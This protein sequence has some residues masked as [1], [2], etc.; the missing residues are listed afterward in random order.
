MSGYWQVE[1]H[2]ADRP[3]TAFGT[4]EGLFQ[5]CVIPFGLSNA[6]ATFQ[7][8][9]DLVLAGLQWSECLVYLDDVIVLGRSFEEHLKNLQSVLQRL[10]QAGLRLKLSKCS[11]FQHQ[12]KYLG[13]IISR[14]GVATDPAKTQKVAH[15]P[16]P[17]SKREVHVQQFLGFAGYYR[18]FIREF[19][20]T[21]RPLH[22]LTERTATFKWT[23]ECAAAFQALHQ[24]LYST[25][26]LAYPDFTRL[27]ILDTDASD[28]GIGAVLS[29]TSSDGNERVIAYGSRL[30]TKPERQYCVTRHELLAVVYFTN[31]Y[32]SYLTGR[33]FVLRTD[34]GSL[35]WL[36]NFEDPEG[37]LAHWLEC[38][39]DLEFE[40]VH[41]R[42]RSHTN[43]DALSRLPCQQC[44][45]E[46]HTTLPSVEIA[47]AALQL[48]SSDLEGEV[49][50]QQ[51]AD[52]VIGPILEAMTTGKKPT[53]AQLI[54]LSKASRRMLHIWDQLTLCDGVMCRRYETADSSST[55]AQIVVP[56][57]LR[58]EVLADLHEGTLGG[59]LGVDKTLARLKERFYWP[60][61]HQDV[62]N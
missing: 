61:H 34:H 20:P 17:S 7:R 59:H 1:M 25:P 55:I 52:P 21:A 50:D 5:F 41:R 43:A 60:G 46:S 56:K 33:K 23:D 6:P 49:R 18:R 2:E 36:R 53:A 3:K 47:A 51:L 54:N 19:A 13:H 22:R 28:T 35:T 14:E 26:V 12:M 9:M 45:Q 40:I 57:A 37:Q 30:L 16:V 42:G 27:F 44:E 32:R 58:D 11:F 39:Q 8:L 48:P 62:R 10:R 31:Q 38:L 24:S 15:W 29:Q 4:T